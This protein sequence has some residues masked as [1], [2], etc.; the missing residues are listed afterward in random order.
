MNKINETLKI[1]LKLLKE[2]YIDSNKIE[3]YLSGANKIDSI[4]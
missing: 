3:V 2:N 1:C 4:N